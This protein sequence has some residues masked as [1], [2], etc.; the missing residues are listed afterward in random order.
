MYFLSVSVLNIY[1]SAIGLKVPF[2][3]LA[4]CWTQVQGRATCTN[5]PEDHERVFNPRLHLSPTL[6]W[7]QSCYDAHVN[8]LKTML[9][10]MELKLC[11]LL[12]K[13]THIMILQSRHSKSWNTVSWNGTLHIRAETWWTN[14]KVRTNQPSVRVMWHTQSDLTLSGQDHLGDR[15]ASGFIL[16]K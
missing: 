6:P 12:W 8:I 13:M 16:G 5:C 4:V 10:L 9:I 15:D 11:K 14:R 3:I 2:Y 1:S 7:V